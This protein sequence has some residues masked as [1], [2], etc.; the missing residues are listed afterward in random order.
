VR[1][2]VISS[3]TLVSIDGVMPVLESDLPTVFDMES[4]ALAR[5]C[6]RRGV[7]FAVIRLISDTPAHPLPHFSSSL[8][9]ALAARTASSRLVHVARGLGGALADPRGVARMVRDG[10]AMLRELTA[11]WAGLAS[12]LKA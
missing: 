12:A 9:A 1:C 6:A 10:A 2:D 11:G 8:A 3:S 5:E 4:A 7:P